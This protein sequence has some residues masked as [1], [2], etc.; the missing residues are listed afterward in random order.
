MAVSAHRTPARARSSVRQRSGQAKR[1]LTAYELAT[2]RKM[3]LEKRRELL[4]DID[5][6]QDEIDE[7]G[8]GQSQDGVSHD[9]DDPEDRLGLETTY[10]FIQAETGLLQDIEEALQRIEDGTYGLCVGTGQ[11]I[12]RRRLKACPWTKYS[13]EYA[14]ALER[15]HR[16]FVVDRG[17]LPDAREGEV[18]LDDLDDDELLEGLVDLDRQIGRRAGRAIR[19][20]FLETEDG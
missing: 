5:G 15:G 3:L 14:R 10:G 12:G 6:M 8:I 9:M 18:E 17:P 16:P 13:I 20:W 4:G 11:P 1:H 7:R 19:K 2:F